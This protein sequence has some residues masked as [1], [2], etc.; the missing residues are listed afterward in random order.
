MLKERGMSFPLIDA[1]S[2]TSPENL[3][4]LIASMNRYDLPGRIYSMKTRANDIA[5][6]RSLIHV[7]R[8]LWH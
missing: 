7:S 4:K 6:K 5:R 3:L 8:K 2:G 1:S